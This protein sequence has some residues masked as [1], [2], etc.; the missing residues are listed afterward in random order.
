LE[1]KG[2]FANN[3]QQANSEI[4]P[5][6]YS[7]HTEI[8]IAGYD[9]RK[10]E[11]PPQM[12]TFNKPMP[13]IYFLN[14]QD[15][16]ITDLRNYGFWCRGANQ[17]FDRYQEKINVNIHSYTLQDAID[18]TRFAFDTSRGLGRY[19]DKEDLISDD[20]EIIAITPYG[21]EWVQ[22][23]ELELIYVNEKH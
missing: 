19:L 11:K 16:K 5:S 4:A 1:I 15:G 7:T 13:E 21:I 20:M 23:K 17:Y 18:I 10:L 12:G 8:F 3:V 6:G 14:T 2:F 9:K 22:K